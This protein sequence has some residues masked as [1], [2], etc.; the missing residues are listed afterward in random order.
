MLRPLGPCVETNFVYALMDWYDWYSQAYGK[1]WENTVTFAKISPPEQNNRNE[2]S[3]TCPIFWKLFLLAIW[4]AEA[5]SA[6]FNC[7]AQELVKINRPLLL[8][9]ESSILAKYNFSLCDN[10][11]AVNLDKSSLP[12]IILEWCLD[13]CSRI[14]P[15]QVNIYKT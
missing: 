10:C 12:S 15:L 3:H 6:G 8:V 13:L 2:E 9:S 1:M 4:S 7:T 5:T 14:L 11:G